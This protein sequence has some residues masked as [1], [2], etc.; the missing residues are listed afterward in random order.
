MATFTKE[1]LSGSTNSRGILISTSGTPTTIHT[2]TTNTAQYEEIWL[3][4]TNY[5]TTARKLTIQWAWPN[6]GGTTGSDE[7]EQTIPAESGL[8]LVVP[9]L[10]IRGASGP[11]TVRGFAA[12]ATSI[13][14]HGYVNRIA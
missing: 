8:V 2:I 11:V 12:T 13:V 9:G 14:V 6:A 7:I 4:A 5:D 10:V 1:T 3:Y